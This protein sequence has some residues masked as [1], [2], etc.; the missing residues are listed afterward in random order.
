MDF[1]SPS[2]STSFSPSPSPV[3]TPAVS[4]SASSHKPSP[5]PRPRGTAGATNNKPGGVAHNASH[6][7]GNSG[8]ANDTA[9]PF[10]NDAVVKG[11]RRKSGEGVRTSFPPS[12][13]QQQHSPVAAGPVSQKQQPQKSGSATEHHYV[14]TGNTTPPLAVMKTSSHQTNV[15]TSQRTVSAASNST[16]TPHPR[17]LEQIEESMEWENSSAQNSH[18]RTAG[19]SGGSAPSVHQGPRQLFVVR[20]GERIDF[21]FGRD[22]IQ[23]SFDKHSKCGGEGGLVI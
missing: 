4:V 7:T 9:M 5:K 17:R 12:Q 20:H 1:P 16:P 18:H 23:S 15:I 6:A 22:W 10:V 8:V 21:T 11:E 13:Q 2:G 19:T 14:N 3:T